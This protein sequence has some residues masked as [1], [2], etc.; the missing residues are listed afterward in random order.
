MKAEENQVTV[1]KG[2]LRGIEIDAR[3]IPDMVPILSVVAC[4]AEG[5]TVIREH[6][7]SV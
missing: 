3:Q 6:N 5:K 2:R 4:G 1:Q 7:G